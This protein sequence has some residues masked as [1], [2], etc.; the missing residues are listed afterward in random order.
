MI[1]Y[2]RP[3]ESCPRGLEVLLYFPA[4]TAGRSRMPDMMRIDR[5][6]VDYPRQPT[7]WAPKPRPPIMPTGEK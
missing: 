4:T 6:P 5:Y 1:D 7:F 2:W 3:I